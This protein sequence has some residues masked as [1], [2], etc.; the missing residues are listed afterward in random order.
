M[1]HARDDFWLEADGV[2]V[3][4]A[5]ATWKIRVRRIGR[6][7]SID[8]E[9][10]AATKRTEAYRKHRRE[11]GDDFVISVYPHGSED[12]YEKVAKA[13]EAA[14]GRRMNPSRQKPTQ[15]PARMARAGLPRDWLTAVDVIV[16]M[17]SYDDFRSCDPRLVTFYLLGLR[18]PKFTADKIRRLTNLMLSSHPPGR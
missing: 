15:A 10:T 13:A 11:L 7:L 16:A 12:L 4:H 9:P 17:R 2:T 18:Y 6:S 1:S 8:L 14:L 3:R 5:G